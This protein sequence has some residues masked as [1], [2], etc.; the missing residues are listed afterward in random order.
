MSSYT[1]ENFQHFILC[2]FQFHHLVLKQLPEEI[3]WIKS[4]FTKKHNFLIF[5]RIFWGR[6]IFWHAL[7]F[8]SGSQLRWRTFLFFGSWWFDQ[9]WRN[10][11]GR[12][13]VVCLISVFHTTC[14]RQKCTAIVMLF[15]T[16]FRA[17]MI[18]IWT[19]G[20][21]TFPDDNSTYILLTSTPISDLSSHTFYQCWPQLMTL[22]LWS[23]KLNGLGAG[24]KSF[25]VFWQSLIDT[26]VAVFQML[27]IFHWIRLLYSLYLHPHSPYIC[28]IF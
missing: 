28:V 23:Q 12:S 24:P 11:F 6:I 18:N 27:F 19:S 26:P 4:N 9:N 13:A 8:F 21:W 16:V 7:K 25:Y 10:A 1:C 15:L 3:C 22:Y 20:C 5:G 14:C 17:I 2:N